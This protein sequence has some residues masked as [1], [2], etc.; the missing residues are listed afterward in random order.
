MKKF[1][2][3]LTNRINYC[4]VCICLDSSLFRM[5]KSMDVIYNKNNCIYIHNRCWKNQE[6]V[7]LGGIMKIKKEELIKIIENVPYDYIDNVSIHFRNFTV[8]ETD[9][10]FDL[11]ID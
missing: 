5:W 3:D 8:N 6:M 9:D 4:V 11:R 7:L 2:Y 10:E 1:I